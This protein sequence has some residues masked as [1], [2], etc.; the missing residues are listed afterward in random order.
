MKMKKYIAALS[1]LAILA[2][3]MSG[4]SQNNNSDTEATIKNSDSKQ[5]TEQLVNDNPIKPGNDDIKYAV[6]YFNKHAYTS[7]FSLNEAQPGKDTYWVYKEYNELRKITLD[8]Y[9]TVD[10]TL[11][12]TLDDGLDKVM[13]TDYLNYWE[14]NDLDETV[15]PEQGVIHES[16]VGTTDDKK[17][18]FNL[19][20]D[21]TT[22]KEMPV[23]DCIIDSFSTGQE[24]E[25]C[26]YMGLH[27]GDT[28]D[29]VIETVGSPNRMLT[30][31]PTG[32]KTYNISM[33]YIDPENKRTT[34]LTVELYYDGMDSEKTK[35]VLT[36]IRVYDRLEERE[37]H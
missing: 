5:S 28:L 16:L 35:A 1:A 33:K 36:K 20:I 17:E 12:I 30:F 21:N 11:T 32:S 31:N 8:D 6:E 26:E 10:G 4:C 22:D 24:G 18:I 23:K 14:Y 29:K 19:Y 25:I 9:M 27:K 13:K 15:S 37:A 3:A 2:A 7:D 34:L